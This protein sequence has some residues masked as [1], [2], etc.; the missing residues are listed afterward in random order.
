MNTL[1]ITGKG[2]AAFHMI[3]RVDP[4]SEPFNSIAAD[5]GKNID[6]LTASR[7]ALAAELAEAR[8]ALSAIENILGYAGIWKVGCCCTERFSQSSGIIL[9][10]RDSG[11][12]SGGGPDAR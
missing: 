2:I 9:A 11:K 12:A 3:G 8:K 1:S 6:D 7:D 4:V 5:I 10:A